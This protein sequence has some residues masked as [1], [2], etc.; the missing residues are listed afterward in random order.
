MK[1]L[2]RLFLE[3]DRILKKYERMMKIKCIGDCYMCAG[4]IFDEINQPAEHTKQTISFGIDIIKAIQLLDIELNES[5]RI[6]VGVNT[7][8]PIV[9][10]VLG[11]EKPTFDIL[12]SAICLA[13]MMEHHGVPMNVHIPQHCYDLVFGTIFRIKE[14]GDVEVKGKMYHTYVVTGYE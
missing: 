5:L 1:T 2:N 12:G 10:G 11:I 3:F 9:A 8:G 13:A 4:G 6:R 14:R 7:G